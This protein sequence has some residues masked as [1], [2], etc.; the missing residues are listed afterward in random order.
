MLICVCTVYFDNNTGFFLLCYWF[1]PLY[2]GINICCKIFWVCL[3]VKCPDSCGGCLCTMDGWACA[4]LSTFTTL[5]SASGTKSFTSLLF[6]NHVLYLSVRRITAY[7]HLLLYLKGQVVEPEL[8][9]W[10][11]NCCLTNCGI[12]DI[13]ICISILWF[14]Q[15]V[16]D[17]IS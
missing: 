10:I 3:V 8:W 15:N 16:K 4:I 2:Q 14:L 13:L 9:V 11:A 12:L 17:N 1:L 5:P 7:C 6:L